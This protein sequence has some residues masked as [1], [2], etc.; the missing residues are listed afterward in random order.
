MIQRPR[1]WT[2]TISSASRRSGEESLTA[3]NGNAT[4]GGGARLRTSLPGGNRRRDEEPGRLRLPPSPRKKARGVRTDDLANPPGRRD[5]RG[6][7]A[8]HPVDE[9][10]I[11]L[12]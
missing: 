7:L 10:D 2:T 9:G 4:A 1:S 6:D 11:V 5:A 12:A 3:S 8:D